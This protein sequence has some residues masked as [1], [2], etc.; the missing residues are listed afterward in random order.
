MHDPA[1]LVAL[2]T[3]VA[4]RS[5]DLLRG[6]RD[7]GRATATAKSTATDMVSEMDRASE[8][9][10]VEE[11][12]AA[13]PGDGVVAEEGSGR[14]GTSGLRWVV[15]PLDGTTNYLYDLPG[16]NV[17]VAAEDA[18]GVVAG[19]VADGVRGEVFSATR[20]G[21]AFRDGRPVRCSGATRL[22]TALVGTGFGYAPERRAAQGAVVGRLLPLVADVRRSGAAALDLC[23]VACGRLD[24]Y[25][26]HGLAWWDLAAGALVASEAGAT[27]LP[28]GS[29][30]LQG[31]AVVAG[32]PA[33]VAPLRD[34]LSALSAHDVP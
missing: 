20:G 14:S 7:R 16:W 21:G 32:A 4:T 29:G 34:L 30:S 22:E 26:E 33:V 27:V 2:A 9:L 5:V 3:R 8:R 10:I 17:S 25:Y 18:D 28:L 12:L 6:G 1:E 15:D 23:S 11:L 31:G 13:R 19:V 24:A